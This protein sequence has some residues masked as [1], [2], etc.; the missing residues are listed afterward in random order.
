MSTTQ[1]KTRTLGASLPL[2]YEAAKILA[3]QG[4]GVQPDSP[5]GE[6]NAIDGETALLVACQRRVEDT[7]LLFLPDPN[8]PEFSKI[9]AGC[10]LRVFDDFSTFAVD[11]TS[12]EEFSNAV[13]C[14]YKAVEILAGNGV[15]ACALEIG[16]EL[17]LA[18]LA[19]PKRKWRIVTSDKHSAV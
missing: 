3:K 7:K 8:R 14:C 10:A 12:S 9:Y 11:E 4:F 5:F 16:I 19:E 6:P 17:R 2:A 15:D 18:M 13:P 1:I